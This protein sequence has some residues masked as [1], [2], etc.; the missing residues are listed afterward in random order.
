MNASGEPA[1][2]V[3]VHPTHSVVG[4]DPPGTLDVGVDP[5]GTLDVGGCCRWLRWGRRTASRCTCGRRGRRWPSSSPGGGVVVDCGGRHCVVVVVRGPSWRRRSS[6]VVVDGDLASTVVV[7]ELVVGGDVL[8]VVDVVGPLP[9]SGSQSNDSEMDSSTVSPTR[10]VSV[11]RDVLDPRDERILV[12]DSGNDDGLVEPPAGDDR[13]VTSV[14]NGLWRS[15]SNPGSGLT[16]RGRRCRRRILRPRRIPATPQPPQRHDRRHGGPDQG[17]GR[18]TRPL[19]DHYIGFA[20]SSARRRRRLLIRFHD[21]RRDS[22]VSAAG[23]RSSPLQRIGVPFPIT[24]QLFHSTIRNA[25]ERGEIL[26]RIPD[27]GT[28]GVGRDSNLTVVSDSMTTVESAL[29]VT[30][31]GPDGEPVARLLG[32]RCRSCGRTFF[33]RASVCPYD[34]EDRD[35]RRG[36]AVE[37]DAVGVD[38]GDG[39]AT[40]LPRTGPLRGRGRGAR[41]TGCASSDGSPGR[42]RRRCPFGQP[43]T[44][45]AETLPTD[46]DPMSIWAFAPAGGAS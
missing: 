38:R 26:P 25:P 23:R 13:D 40:G 10:T 28:D 45:V 37:R 32:G 44:T 36:P 15:T 6:I 1:R 7:V 42:T 33:P 19:I 41:R 3:V 21:G 18:R 27:S 43:M 17:L 39:C 35:R 9:S 16:R 24:A 20:P 4:V 31:E 34:G 14:S 46:G 8:V 12:V 29:F 2:V 5:P 11:D 30:S 22:W